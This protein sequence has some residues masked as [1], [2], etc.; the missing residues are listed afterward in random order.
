MKNPGVSNPGVAF[1]Q[2]YILF[3]FFNSSL[4]FTISS[5]VI[6]IIKIKKNKMLSEKYIK[7]AGAEHH[8]FEKLYL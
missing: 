5:N 7:K 6:R 3:R 4:L 2:S 8:Y 1:F